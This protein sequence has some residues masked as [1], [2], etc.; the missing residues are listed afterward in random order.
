MICDTRDREINCLSHGLLLVKS[1]LKKINWDLSD[2][3]CLFKSFG[4]AFSKARAD[5]TR[6]ALVA[7]RT[8]RNNLIVRKRHRGVNVKPKAWQRGTAQVGGSPLLHKGVGGTS[9]K[10]SEFPLLHKGYLNSLS[11]FF[12]DTGSAKKKA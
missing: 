2:R 4:R 5:P 11:A 3:L 8:R 6:A 7:A 12:F 9:P 1:V 10:R